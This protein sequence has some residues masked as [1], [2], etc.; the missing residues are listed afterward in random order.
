MGRTTLEILG[1]AGYSKRER[2]ADT[3]LLYLRVVIRTPEMKMR[4]PTL[5]SDRLDRAVKDAAEKANLYLEMLSRCMV[6]G[7]GQPV[8]SVTVAHQSRVFMDGA[9]VRRAWFQLKPGRHW[10]QGPTS[11]PRSGFPDRVPCERVLE[12]FSQT[13]WPEHGFIHLP[14][15]FEASLGIHHASQVELVT[16]MRAKGVEFYYARRGTEGSSAAR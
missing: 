8:D 13:S 6:Y 2:H 9:T 5:G 4:W 11:R 16:V 10:V 3:G 14:A 1:E 12:M 7:N 15:C